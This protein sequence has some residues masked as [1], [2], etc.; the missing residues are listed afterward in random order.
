MTV[1]EPIKEI[2][3][4]YIDFKKVD[5]DCGCGDCIRKSIQVLCEKLDAYDDFLKDLNELQDNEGAA[6]TEIRPGVRRQPG[7]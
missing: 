7:A 1:W 3:Q 6:K 2:E 5:V 4:A